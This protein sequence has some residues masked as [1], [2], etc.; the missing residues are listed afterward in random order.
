MFFSSKYSQTPERLFPNPRATIPKPPSD[1]SQT[2]ERLTIPE[3]PK[4][5]L[6]IPET[7]NYNIILKTP[8]FLLLI[9]E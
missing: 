7:P 3:T 5:F 2:P 6:Y 9:L 4:F 1:Y 8:N